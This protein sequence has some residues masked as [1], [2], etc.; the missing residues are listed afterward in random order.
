[1][2]VLHQNYVTFGCK[3]N[4]TSD[5]SNGFIFIGF[6]STLNILKYNTVTVHA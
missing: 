2:K 3:Y 6:M 1:M 5:K 4:I